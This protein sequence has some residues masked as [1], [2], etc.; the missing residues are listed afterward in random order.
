NRAPPKIF[1][2][3]IFASGKKAYMPP[4]KVVITMNVMP[5][6]IKDTKPRFRKSK[7]CSIYPVKAPSRGL[8]TREAINKKLKPK[9][10]EKEMT[11]SIIIFNLPFFGLGLIRQIS[12]KDFWISINMVVDVAI[13]VPI[14]MSIPI[15]D[16]LSKEIF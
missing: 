16:L 12:F 5:V 11:L 4:N 8:S 15:L 1:L 6:L 10:I 13:R 14:P 9:I 2:N 7:Y 3:W